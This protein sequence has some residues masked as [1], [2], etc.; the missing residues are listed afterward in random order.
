L[1]LLHL[2]WF[3]LVETFSRGTAVAAQPTSILPRIACTPTIREK[4]K[5]G[6]KEEENGI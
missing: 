5:G 1:F 3:L 4:D 2:P 6:R